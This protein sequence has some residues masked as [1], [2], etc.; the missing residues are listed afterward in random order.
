MDSAADRKSVRVTIFHQTYTLSASG[1]AAEV[2][3]LAHSVDEL[4][5]GIASRAGNVDSSRV[6]VLT[7]LHLA[8]RLRTAERELDGLKH[9]IDAK[10]REF[11][12][13]LDQTLP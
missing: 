12:M 5:V 2:E 13:I 8:D 3:A 9:R 7:C 11:S 4:M 1:D 6:A 10:A